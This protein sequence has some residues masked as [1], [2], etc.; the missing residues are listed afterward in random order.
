M[1]VDHKHHNSQQD[2]DGSADGQFLE[3]GLAV[4]GLLLLVVVEVVQFGLGLELVDYDLC[5]VGE[6]V[7][8][9]AGAYPGKYPHSTHQDTC[10]EECVADDLDC[11]FC[12]CC[13]EDSQNGCY[14]KD[15]DSRSC[16]VDEMLFGFACPFD[17]LVLELFVVFHRFPLLQDLQVLVELSLVAVHEVAR[18]D[19]T[20]G[21]LVLSV[22]V[23]N[24]RVVGDSLP[25]LLV[26]RVRLRDG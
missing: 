22:V 20:E 11:F 25:A 7:E 10:G 19:L 8:G 3:P 15:S 16:R 18:L 24:K 13:L 17:V 26:F 23:V 14:G 12:V 1:V 21:R 2:A 9:A 6:D 4:L 5:G